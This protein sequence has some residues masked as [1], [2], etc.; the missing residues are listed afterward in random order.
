LEELD[1]ATHFVLFTVDPDFKFT[2]GGHCFEDGYAKGTGKQ[3]AI[4]G[5]RQMVFH[6][7]PGTRRFEIWKT[8]RDWLIEENKKDEEELSQARKS[9]DKS[10]L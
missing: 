2:R 9:G 7:L 5:P 1:Q 4:I 8:C 3:R 10:G 6:Y